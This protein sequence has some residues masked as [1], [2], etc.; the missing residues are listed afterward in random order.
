M[1]N[2]IPPD[3]DFVVL[4]QDLLQALIEV[5]LQVLVA[6]HAVCV[7][8]GLNLR[9]LI[10]ML[11]VHLVS[12]NVEVGVGKEF[13]H[14]PDEFVEEF[15]GLFSGG[16]SDRVRSLGIDF[17]R[18]GTAGKLGISDKTRT[19][20]G[21]SLELPQ[22]ADAAV[23]RVG[24]EITNVILGV[25]QAIGTHL[26]QPG[27]LLALDAKTLVVGKMQM[28]NVHLHGSHSIQ[29]ALKHIERNK[30]TANVNEQSAPGE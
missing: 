27:K 6:F 23:V 25:I 21:Q 14:L 19:A 30:V 29:I 28:Q 7:N 10:P 8:E 3:H 24:N 26:M 18:T 9:I 4:R 20:V 22:H 15:V 16:I 12:A 2:L 13:G 11:A 17:E 5:G 1:Q